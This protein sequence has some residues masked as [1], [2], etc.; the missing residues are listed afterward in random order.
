MEIKRNVIKIPKGKT[1]I[2]VGEFN[3]SR[4][5]IYNALRD[6]TQSKLAKDIRTRAIELLQEE[7]NEA[8]I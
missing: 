2:L 3:V 8:K 1:D 6:V 4:M 5:S 7:I